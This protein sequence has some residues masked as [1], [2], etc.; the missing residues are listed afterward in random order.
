MT[1]DVQ[2]SV[3]DK[4]LDSRLFAAPDHPHPLFSPVA[5]LLLRFLMSKRKAECRRRWILRGCIGGCGVRAAC[6]ACAGATRTKS[7]GYIVLARRNP[8]FVPGGASQPPLLR[9]SPSGPQHLEGMQHPRGTHAVP[10]PREAESVLPS[11]G[12]AAGSMGVLRGGSMHCH[13]PPKLQ[14]P[15]RGGR[16]LLQTAPPPPLPPHCRRTRG[17]GCSSTGCKSRSFS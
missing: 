11:T 6:T 13:P 4:V 17:N 9:P 10:L 8:G 12:P 16:G 1:P 2:R 3:H 5:L 14:A 15:Q 7:K